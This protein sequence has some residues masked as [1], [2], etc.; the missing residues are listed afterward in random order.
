MENPSLGIDIGGDIPD[1]GGHMR[2][3]FDHILDLADGGENSR[4]V[5]V[6][7]FGADVVERQIRQRPHKVHCDLTGEGDVLRAV[8]PAQI[9]ALEG[10]VAGGLANDDL[11]RRDKDAVVDDVGSGRNG[12]FCIN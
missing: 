11:R 8:L 4:M 9:L 5:A 3:G 6:F 7:K 1:R 2:V 10:V 12:S